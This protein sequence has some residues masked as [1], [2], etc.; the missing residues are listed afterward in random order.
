MRVTEGQARSADG[1]MLFTRTWLPEGEPRAVLGMAHGGGEHS[2]R[3]TEVGAALAEGGYALHMADLR[4]HGKSP[5]K[6]GHM[7]NWAEYQADFDAIVQGARAAAPGAPLFIGGLSLGGL[8]AASA[9]LDPPDGADGVI[10]VSPFFQIAWDPGAGKLALANLLAGVFPR[11]ALSQG[12]TADM[13]SRSPEVVARYERD[14]LVHD[15]ATLRAAQQI[16]N[17]QAHTLAQAQRLTLPLLMLIGT[18]DRLAAPAAGRQFFGDVSSAD[19]T[20]HV[21]DGL[22]HEVLNEPE[23]AAVLADLIQWLD[24]RTDAPR[25]PGD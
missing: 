6:R 22:Y 12:I 9:A 2:G 14:P 4:G 25:T 11:L 20:L 10:L 1:L 16:L 7:M 13:V 17:A 24:A 23:R 19:K 8:I 21:Y 5:G 15:R 18:E 3:Y